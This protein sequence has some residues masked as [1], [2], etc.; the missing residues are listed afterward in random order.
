MS[1][2]TLGPVE[3][4][5]GLGPGRARKPQ[6]WAGLGPEPEP[7]KSLLTA[8]VHIHPAGPPNPVHLLSP[9]SNRVHIWELNTPLVTLGVRMA[10]HKN[11]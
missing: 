2:P 7:G 3:N 6:A 1:G 8:R 10:G 4:R 5:V 9:I 11:S